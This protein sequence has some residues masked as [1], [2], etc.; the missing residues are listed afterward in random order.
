MSGSNTKISII[1]GDTDSFFLK[2]KNLRID[3]LL[4]QMISDGHLDSSNYPAG[5]KFFSNQYKAQ[6]GCVKNECPGVAIREIIMLR[7]KSY[8]ILLETDNAKKRAK[9]VQRHVVE[10]V[11]KHKDYKE[12]YEETA[13]LHFETRRIGSLQHQLFTLSQTKLP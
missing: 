2:L 11:V 3:T 13:A 1:G 10:K 8:S 4:K 9:G 12:A 7:P 6:P 5:H